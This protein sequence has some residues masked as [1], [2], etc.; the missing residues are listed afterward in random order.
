MLHI[1]N[2]MDRPI[3]EKG[4]MTCKI[5]SQHKLQSDSS[6]CFPPSIECQR[7]CSI[8]SS[9]SKTI[10][11]NINMRQVLVWLFLFPALLKA[12]SLYLSRKYLLTLSWTDY[13]KTNISFINW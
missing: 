6:V 2:G 3:F 10:A 12:N 7:G 1:E 8:H 13:R 11:S 5:F 4:L 9:T